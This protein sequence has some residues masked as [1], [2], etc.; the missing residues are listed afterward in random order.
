MDNIVQDIR[1]INLNRRSIL[2]RDGSCRVCGATNGL[3]LHHI[4]PIAYGLECGVPES[5]FNNEANK[6]ALCGDCHIYYE[7]RRRSIYSNHRYRRI[8]ILTLFSL[9]SHLSGYIEGELKTQIYDKVGRWF[10]TTENPNVKCAVVCAERPYRC[11]CGL[12]FDR[13]SCDQPL[14]MPQEYHIKAM[15]P[16]SIRLYRMS[17]ECAQ[18]LGFVSNNVC[19]CDHQDGLL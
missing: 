17:I 2:V 5:I 18:R 8:E 15:L 14:L 19:Y 16:K 9:F 11:K 13:K 10:T 1:R 4:L 7:A 12:F 6:V 3:H